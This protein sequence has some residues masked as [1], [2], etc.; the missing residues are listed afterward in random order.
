[1]KIH[2]TILL[3]QFMGSIE[4]TGTYNNICDNFFYLRSISG[5]VQPPPLHTHT[6]NQLISNMITV[7]WG[8]LVALRLSVC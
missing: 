1:M 3:D 5:G 6:L 8:C 2:N 7:C 4:I